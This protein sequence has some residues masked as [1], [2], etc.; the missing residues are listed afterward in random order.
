MIFLSKDIQV[1]YGLGLNNLSFI[2]EGESN[3]LQS[4]KEA[5]FRNMMEKGLYLEKQR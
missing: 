5:L 1:E 2:S 3:D 4:Y